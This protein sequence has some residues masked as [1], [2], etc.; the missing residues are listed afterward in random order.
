MMLARSIGCNER[1]GCVTGMKG[2]GADA[3]DVGLPDWLVML[4]MLARSIGCNERL[5]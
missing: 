5:S 1:L 3:H 4:M 2:L